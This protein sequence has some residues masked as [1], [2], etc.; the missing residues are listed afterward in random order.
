[1]DGAIRRITTTY[2]DI[3]RV[4][5]VASHDDPDPGEGNVVNQEEK[6]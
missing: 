3:G 4:E 2:D 1:V 5:T 6:R